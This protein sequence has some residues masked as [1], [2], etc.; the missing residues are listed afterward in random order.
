MNSVKIKRKGIGLTQLQFAQQIGV[1]LRTYKRYESDENS[2]EYRE[3]K[4]TMAIKIADA[5]GVENLRELWN[6]KKE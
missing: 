1:P 2:T 4:A 3:P 6:Y 5:L